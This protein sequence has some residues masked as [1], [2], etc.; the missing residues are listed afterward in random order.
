MNNIQKIELLNGYKLVA[1]IRDSD[2]EIELVQVNWTKDSHSDTFFRLINKL[3]AVINVNK[4]Y[5]ENA[6]KQDLHGIFCGW[7]GGLNV[8]CDDIG[9]FYITN[10]PKIDSKVCCRE[11]YYSDIG[12]KHIELYGV[13][14]R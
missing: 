9:F 1:E 2:E 8:F 6:L 12:K 10:D 4:N 5:L 14:E 7:C 11:C 3:N 13:G